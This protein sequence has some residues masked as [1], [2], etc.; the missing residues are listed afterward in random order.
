MPILTCFLGGCASAA[1]YLMP[2]FD[3]AVVL[4]YATWL[5][6][7]GWFVGV[8][9]TIQRSLPPGRA[10]DSGI[11]LFFAVS[12]LVGALNVLGVSQGGVDSASAS[13]SPSSADDMYSGDG[14]RFFLDR[15][16]SAL[17]VDGGARDAARRA[18]LT[19]GL[20]FAVLI[21]CCCD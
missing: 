5:L 8:I 18:M 7:E 14:H 20:I 12:G 21:L 10:R 19:S 9:T 2:T 11:G 16:W 13:A 17:A 4:L 1:L 6:G 15:L 3:A